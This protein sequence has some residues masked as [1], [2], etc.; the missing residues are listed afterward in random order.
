MD[1]LSLK[2]IM[3]WLFP[4]KFLQIIKPYIV[5]KYEI[6][7][8]LPFI[9]IKIFDQ[10]A[11]CDI[12]RWKQFRD[13]MRQKI[14]SGS[15]G[16][17]ILNAGSSDGNLNQTLFCKSPIFEEPITEQEFFSCFDYYTLEYFD[18]DL[19]KVKSGQQLK[20]FYSDSKN[21]RNIDPS[22]FSQYP[23]GF[24]KGHITADLSSREILKKYE[25]YKGFFDFIFCLDVLEHVK[26]PFIGAEAL[27]FL[28]KDGG[29][30]LVI[31][32]FSYPYH[33]D[34]QD[35]W[36]FTHTGIINLFNSVDTDIT[37]YDPIFCGYDT[38][39]R[40][41]NLKGK[42]IPIDSFGGWRESWM[43]YAH[44]RK[45]INRPKQADLPPKLKTG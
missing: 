44:L 24:H 22:L 9:K 6:I 36:R 32:P 3:V 42:G 14:E 7:I 37:I 16:L 2:K 11:P 35:Y 19:N 30:I 40:R 41:K 31:T 15:K 43:T 45:R 33:E 12:L 10:V 21:F 28:L 1:L 18:F 29:E 26:N 39:G 27:D 4:L 20:F 25:C 8:N 17:K 34:P 38:S 23:D 5:H 13:L